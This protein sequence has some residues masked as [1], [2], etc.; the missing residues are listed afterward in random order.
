MMGGGRGDEAIVNTN[1]NKKRVKRPWKLDEIEKRARSS[2]IQVRRETSHIVRSLVD[3]GALSFFMS[4]YV[5]AVFLV[6]SLQRAHPGTP[7]TIKVH[8]AR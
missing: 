1:F 8:H 4:C 2:A 5:L 7:I 6:G 3:L